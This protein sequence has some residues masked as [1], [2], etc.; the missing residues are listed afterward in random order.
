M[1]NESVLKVQKTITCRLGNMW[2]GIYKRLA[3]FHLISILRYSDII[4]QLAASLKL[5]QNKV[6]NYLDTVNNININDCNT[7]GTKI[8]SYRRMD[9]TYLDHHHG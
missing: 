9:S 3:F 4:H 8:N 7:F 5:I 6:F 1:S 2:T